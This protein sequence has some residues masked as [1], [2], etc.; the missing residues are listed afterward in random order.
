MKKTLKEKKGVIYNP[1]IGFTS[2]QHFR[3]EALYSDCI[4][5]RSSGVAS[6]ETENYECYPVPVGVEEKGR[7]QGYYPDTTVAY[8]RIL[9]K[10]FEPEQGEYNY[11]LIE[12]VLNKAKQKGQTVMFR[13]MPHSTCARDDVPDWLKLIMPCPERPDGMRVKASPTDPRYL[14]LFSKAIEKLGERFDVNNTL[15]C[16]DVALGGAWGE[17]SQ[18]FPEEDIRALMDVYVRAFPHTKLI[19]QLSNT[20]MLN[21]ISEKH[22]IGWRADG[23]GCPR[24]MNEIFPK[25]IAN[26]KKEFWKTAPVSFESYWWI[27]EWYRQGWDIDSIIE[28]TLKWHI[29]TFNTKSFPIQYE[30]REKI[31]YWL[32][33]MGYRFVIREVEFPDNISAGKTIKVLFKIENKGVAPIYNKLPLKI[34]IKGEKTKEYITDVDI[35]KWLPGEHTETVYFDVFDDILHGKYELQIAIGGDKNP[36]VQFANEGKTD[37]DYFT[38]GELLIKE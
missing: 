13:L 28:K 35:T 12:D 37:G 21:Y 36:N 3:G 5:N 23:T 24:H 33:R 9:W 32:E 22:K 14:K 2:F 31:E 30:W 34:R 8:I 6:C 38:L 17:G 4:T 20:S 27:S 26:M 25:H 18:S 15:D 7:E 19:G 1:Y 11:D 29:S 10:E 16:V